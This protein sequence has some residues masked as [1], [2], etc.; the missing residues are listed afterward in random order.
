A[1]SNT[2]H[3]R[4][5]LDRQLAKADPAPAPQGNP[6]SS[7]PSPR[8]L[9]REPR[10]TPR[11]LNGPSQPLAAASRRLALQPRYATAAAPCRPGAGD[12]RLAPERHRR[13]SPRS[14]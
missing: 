4:A 11:G 8:S 6:F 12:R 3:C 13:F 10:P 14:R 2:L 5:A 9:S 1:T 7:P